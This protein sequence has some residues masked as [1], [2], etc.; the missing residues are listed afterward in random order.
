MVWLFLVD[1]DG[2]FCSFT[3]HITPWILFLVSSVISV[4][5]PTQKNVFLH[6]QIDILA[7]LVFLFVLVVFDG[8]FSAFSQSLQSK[9]KRNYNRYVLYDFISNF[10]VVIYL[11]LSSKWPLSTPTTDNNWHNSDSVVC[12]SSA[13]LSF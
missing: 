13:N 12:R 1:F 5:A 7:L 6:Q 4:C 10:H 11:R 9:D 8:C 2:F 3:V